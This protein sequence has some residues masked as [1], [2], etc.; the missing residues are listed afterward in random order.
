MSVSPRIREF[1]DELDALLD[2]KDW[3]GLDRDALTMTP[4]IV[5]VPRR[6]GVTASRVC[7]AASDVTAVSTTNAVKMRVIACAP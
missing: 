7:C 3:P 6:S 4:S 1:L 2:G 5:P